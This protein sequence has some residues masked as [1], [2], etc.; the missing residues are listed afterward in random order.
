M[1]R[2]FALLAFTFIVANLTFA[3]EWQTETVDDPEDTPWATSIALDSNDYPHI[4]YR[5]DGY[6]YDV[7]YARWDG[8]QWQLE[9]INEPGDYGGDVSIAI[10]SGDNPHI[11]FRDY[12]NTA[13][14][15]AK[16]SGSSWQI[17]TVDSEGA[18]GGQASI[19]LDS[20]DNPH[21]SYF[22]WTN[23]QL[24]YAR[25]DGSQWQIEAVDANGE[26][27][28]AWSQ[29]A[30]D[31]LNRPHISYIDYIEWEKGEKG[32]QGELRYAKKEGGTWQ[33]EFVDDTD[34][35]ATYSVIVLDSGDNPHI[36]Y[37]GE[38]NLGEN[39]HHDLKYARRDGSGWQIETVRESG[40]LGY[41]HISIAIDSNDYPHISYYDDTSDD[42]AYARWDGGE[43]QFET[44]ATEYY[45]GWFNDIALDSNDS[46]HISYRHSITWY[47]G[48]E[49]RYAWYGPLG[50]END[51][52]PTTP[53]GF[54][55]CSAAPNPSEGSA[56][57]GF[58]LP[59]ACEA[60]LALYDIKGRKVATLAE[61]KHQPGEYSAVVNGL[62]SG[63]YIYEL[64]ADEFRESK[65][66][67]VK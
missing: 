42:L 22:D 36:S 64:T 29:I 23:E 50:F 3:D 38:S 56:S 15:Y 67:I 8:N 5:Q 35:F 63:V 59:R 58:A 39:N 30:I 1:S 54:V 41:L 61:G 19:A 2:L 53:T 52:I 66:M 18:V 27:V 25:W 62:S 10:D 40:T 11:V 34:S 33:I 20:G 44:V 60:E 28:G 17:E 57:I 49:L 47:T 7:E 43:W 32:D 55:L 65:K 13:L 14:M 6:D 9:T 51:D 24:K 45:S 46:P 31:S 21:I 16:K 12:A 26:L 48:A 37:I 4:V